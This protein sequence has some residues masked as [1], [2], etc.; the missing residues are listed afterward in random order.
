MK[1]IVLLIL[2]GLFLLTSCGVS[3]AVRKVEKYIDIELSTAE[4]LSE[5]ETH[6]GF[7]GDGTTFITLRCDKEAAA[8]IEESESFHKLPLSADVGIMLYGSDYVLY[9][10]V[11][12]SPLS[13]GEL[14]PLFPEIENGYYFFLDRHP[15]ASGE[16]FDATELLDRYSYNFIVAIYDSDSDI[17]YF[18]KFDT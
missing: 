7:H 12:R 1:R 6:G 3:S 16:S 2:C 13:D 17:L 14:N 18:C 9:S 11:S 15:D 4:V 10:K 8:E 5:Y